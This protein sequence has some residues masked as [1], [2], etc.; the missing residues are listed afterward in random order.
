MRLPD[1]RTHRWKA[2]NA[3]RKQVRDLILS[4]LDQEILTPPFTDQDWRELLLLLRAMQP[5]DADGSIECGIQFE[6]DGKECFGTVD[7]DC[8]LSFASVD[9]DDVRVQLETG[10]T[11]AIELADDIQR[12]PYAA[13]LL[14][15]VK[16]IACVQDLALIRRMHTTRDAWLASKSGRELRDLSS[17]GNVESALAADKLV[18]TAQEL[19]CFDKLTVEATDLAEIDGCFCLPIARAAA[20]RALDRFSAK[21]RALFPDAVRDLEQPGAGASARFAL[22]FSP[23]QP[24]S[25]I[26]KKMNEHRNRNENSTDWLFTTKVLDASSVHA[27]PSN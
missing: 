24:E 5:H 2:G 26:R 9:R 13:Q 3:S 11:M 23:L 17:F 7:S 20:G 16:T 6:L 25:T 4:W 12:I 27:S 19:L 15:A 14:T 1:S 21:L 8:V 10:N 22:L 18:A